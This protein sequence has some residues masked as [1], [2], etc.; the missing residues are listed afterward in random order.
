[1]LYCTVLYCTV[2]YLSLATLIRFFI[3]WSW[4]AIWEHDLLYFSQLPSL[5]SLSRLIVIVIYINPVMTRTVYLCSRSRALRQTTQLVSTH[6]RTYI[7]IHIHTSQCTVCWWQ[8]TYTFR[9]CLHCT[10]LPERHIYI[11]THRGHPAFPICFNSYRPIGFWSTQTILPL[12]SISSLSCLLHSFGP[13]LPLPFLI[14]HFL[15]LPGAQVEEVS[16]SLNSED[17][18]VLTT[19]KSIYVWKGKSSLWEFNYQKTHRNLIAQTL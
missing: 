12:H 3:S 5:L 14:Y 17:V 15:C 11:H 19:P 9:C 7:Y 13:S 1:M 16:A 18:F 8:H 4:G 2:L 6:T 10:L